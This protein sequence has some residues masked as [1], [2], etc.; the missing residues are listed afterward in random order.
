MVV[1]RRQFLTLLGGAAV[2]PLAARAQPSGQIRRVGVLVPFNDFRDPQVQ[3]QWSAFTHRMRE[4]GWIEDRNIR[5]EV[6]FTGQNAERIRAG[7]QQLVST[8]P[9]IIFVWANP[10]LAALRDL[11][12]TIPI[13]FAQV[14]D[15]LGSGL[16][17]NLARPVGNITGFQNF[18]PE[19]GGKWLQLLAEI[20]PDVTHVAYL[21][22]Q[23]IAANVGFLKSAELASTS[24]R[25]RLVPIAERGAT[26]IEAA[27]AAFAREP[28]GGLI[29]APNPTN[30]IN[31]EMI[32][33]LAARLH[34]PAIYPFRLDAVAGGLV[35]YGFDVIE[36][37]RGAAVYV[38]RILRGARPEE[39]PVQLPTKYQL[40]INLKTARTLGLNVSFQLQQRA[41][42][43]IE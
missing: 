37:Q 1:G 17:A 15:P 33:G 8:G 4:L 18:E 36:Q 43:V 19:I 22:N 13:V 3:E 10:A 29:V 6:Q 32:I 14:S 40:L 9:D 26:N 42:E 34:L 21:Y 5:F 20:A 7:A 27:V 39:L 30:T 12:R 41:D 35:S 2:W 11:T 16:V 25:M 24:L 31:R 38:N 28:N 23:N